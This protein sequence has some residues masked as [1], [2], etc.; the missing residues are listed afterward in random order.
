MK[1]GGIT[2]LFIFSDSS[3]NSVNLKHIFLSINTDSEISSALNFVT[4][5][6]FSAT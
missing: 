5:D 1:K 4:P 6:N 2:V 3:V